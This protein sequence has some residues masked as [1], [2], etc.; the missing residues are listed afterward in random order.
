MW[1]LA[2]TYI[3]RASMHSHIQALT[4][5]IGIY[6]ILHFLLNDK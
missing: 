1:A 2:H 6:E 3:E 5:P 4:F